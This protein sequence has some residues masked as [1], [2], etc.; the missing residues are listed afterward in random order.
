MRTILIIILTAIT[1]QAQI[2]S[3]VISDGNYRHTAVAL[4][5]TNSIFSDTT[6]VGDWELVGNDTLYIDGDSSLVYSNVPT[7]L[8]PNPYFDDWS[9][10]ELVTN[11]TF[12]GGTTGWAL[13]AN[14]TYG[15]NDLDGN[16]TTQYFYQSLAHAANP[17][18]ISYDIL[19]YTSGGFRA[20]LN[21]GVNGT[22]NSGNGTYEEVLQP[23]GTGNAIFQPIGGGFVGTIDNIS[24]SV[25]IAPDGWTASTMD[26]DNYV[27]QDDDGIR[28]VGDGTSTLNISLNGQMVVGKEYIIKVVVSEKNGSGYVYN[29]VGDGVPADINYST[30]GTHLDTIT[31]DGTDITISRKNGAGAIDLVIPEISIKEYHE[32]NNIQLPLTVIDGQD[33]RLTVDMMEGEED[34]LDGWD[35]TDSWTAVS[36]TVLDNNSFS[37]VG[38]GGVYKSGIMTS[39]QSYKIIIEGTTTASQI[40]L[41]YGIS[42]S[43]FSYI[44]DGIINESLVYS[45]SGTSTN[46]LGLYFRNAGAGITDITK[47]EVFELD[48]ES[49]SVYSQP[50]ITVE[51]KS[52][53]YPALTS[54]NQTFTF[55]FEGSGV[56]DT[57]SISLSDTSKAKIDNVTLKR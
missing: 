14:W 1:L 55:D 32:T 28:F 54:S 6:T 7:E 35:F 40:Q 46:G 5:D 21:S 45:A 37:T 22:T 30:V 52:L 42:G 20:V 39:G 24:V 48:S 4:G 2:T 36:A 13:Q 41:R 47:L 16:V 53:T 34:L 33:Y 15:D 17:V 50:T 56:A 25:L 19:D 23:A 18:V 31:A 11:G 9:Y 38:I 57:V 12:T 43:T 27:I 10:V 8:N 44:N 51:D 29:W 3:M 26:E 49:Q